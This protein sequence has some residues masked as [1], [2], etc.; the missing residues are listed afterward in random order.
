MVIGQGL[1]TPVPNGLLI[2]L[3]STTYIFEA[4]CTMQVEVASPTTPTKIE[5][6][7]KVKDNKSNERNH[8]CIPLM[9]SSDKNQMEVTGN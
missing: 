2:S 4:I 8:G 6:L 9:Y 7:A 1:P 3:H 5:I